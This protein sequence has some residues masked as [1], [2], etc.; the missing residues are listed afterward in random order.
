MDKTAAIYDQLYNSIPP[1]GFIN[2]KKR[3]V[4]FLKITNMLQVMVDNGEV[5]E[6]DGLYV[7]SVLVRKCSRFQKAAMMAALNL[8][9]IDRKLISAIGFRYANDF[10]CSLRLYPV[11][12]IPP[13]P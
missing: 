4:A 3:V 6:D 13:Q 2:R 9:T 1:I 11:D 12:D 10:R 5:S 7:L 8:P